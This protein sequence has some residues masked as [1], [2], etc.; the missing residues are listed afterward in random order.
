MAEFPCIEC[1]LDCDVDTIQCSNC[2][3]WIHRKCAKI[4]ESEFKSWSDRHL[5]YLCK[6]CVFIGK[7]YDA[8]G[9][10]KR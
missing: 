10:L 9:A 4:S 7:D 8:A 3:N 2:H 5:N 6:C 1:T